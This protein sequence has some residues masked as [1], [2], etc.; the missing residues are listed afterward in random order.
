MFTYYQLYTDFYS[1]HFFHWLLDKMTQETV[2]S[3]HYRTPIVGADAYTGPRDAGT[4]WECLFFDFVSP[5]LQEA[6]IIEKVTFVGRQ[7]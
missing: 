6:G 2:A 7:K 1:S 3:S 5:V 4:S